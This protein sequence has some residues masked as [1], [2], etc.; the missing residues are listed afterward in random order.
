MFWRVIRLE[1]T[2]YTQKRYLIMSTA[3]VY[4]LFKSEYPEANIKLSK[5]RDLRPVDVDIF[6]HLPQNVCVCKTHE[7]MRHLV[8]ALHPHVGLPLMNGSSDDFVEALTCDPTNKNCMSRQC[9]NCAMSLDGFN[10]QNIGGN[11]MANT[12]VTVIQWQEDGKLTVQTKSEM[13]L[14]DCYE[15][16]KKQLRGLIHIYV[17]REQ[18]NYFEKTIKSVNGHKVSCPS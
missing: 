14:Q 10:P 9:Q 3:E 4:S 2:H 12:K 16:V 6:N 18:S 5:L 15:A 7:N 13:T 17:K 8:Q 11:R 1:V